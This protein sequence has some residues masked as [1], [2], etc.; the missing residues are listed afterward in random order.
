MMTKVD[1]PREMARLR[2]VF[3]CST[4]IMMVNQ[5][6]Q[7]LGLNVGYKGTIEDPVKFDGELA[8]PNYVVCQLPEPES[9]GQSIKLHV[10]TQQQVLL[11]LEAYSP[12]AKTEVKFKKPD[13][14]E[15]MS[16]GNYVIYSEEG[17]RGAALH[18]LEQTTG[19]ILD[20]A[21]MRGHQQFRWPA[22][23]E[24]K[25]EGN[26]RVIFERG[27]NLAEMRRVLNKVDAGK[28]P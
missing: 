12:I 5:A 25:I 14:F 24:L 26:Y 19:A 20:S 23:V 22:F 3:S 9:D 17:A 13:D 18:F 8:E 1:T 4:Q 6:R 28:A 27:M 7:H 2:R 15:Y 21:S 10:Y 11:A 16:R